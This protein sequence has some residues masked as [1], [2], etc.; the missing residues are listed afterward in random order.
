[1]PQHARCA[2]RITE[3]FAQT[4]RKPLERFTDQAATRAKIAAA[5]RGTLGQ[6][7]KREEVLARG[8]C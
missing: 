3:K 2:L 8:D 1:M 6:V 4:R 7:K 5:P